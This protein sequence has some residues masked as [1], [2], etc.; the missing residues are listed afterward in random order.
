M[1]DEQYMF[2]MLRNIVIA[3]RRGED[4]SRWLDAAEAM[5]NVLELTPRF[6]SEERNEQ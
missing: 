4:L 3:W 1:T 6:G 5:V 2:N